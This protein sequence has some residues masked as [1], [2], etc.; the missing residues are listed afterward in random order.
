MVDWT[1]WHNEPLLIGALVLASWLYALAVG[2]WRHRLSPGAEAPRA[3]IIR[4]ACGMVVF[5]L[6]VGSPLDQIGERF[7]FS[8]HMLQHMI[9]VYLVAPLI[10]TG[11][12]AWLLDLPLRPPTARA[13]ARVLFSPVVAAV[14]Y[15]LCMSAWHVPVAYDLALRDKLVHVVQHLM[16]LAVALGFWWP[17][18]SPS[19]LVPQRPPAVQVLYVFGVGVL[20]FPLVA[21]L[22][23][24][25]E[26]LYPTYAFAPRLINLSPRDDQVLGGALMG[27]GGMFIALGLV[28][29]AFYQ[30]AGKSPA[31]DPS[32]VVPTPPS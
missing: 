17:L 12:P 10:L 22:N 15:V 27:V 7:L 1:H 11:M 31:T 9:I 24:S 19:R 30:W 29:R 26:A 14:A 28:G 32:P 23:F 6:A 16:F 3:Q 4:F 5:Y 21:F 13:V 20:Q 18:A 25:R 2:P 8:A